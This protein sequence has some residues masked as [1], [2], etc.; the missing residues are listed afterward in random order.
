VALAECWDVGRRSKGQTEGTGVAYAGSGLSK[1][2]LTI[3][4]SAARRRRIAIALA[5][6]M[7]A[8]IA[9]AAQARAATYTVGITSDATGTCSVPSSG[10]CSLRQLIG[11]E[12][13]LSSTP[14]PAD[15][16]VLPAG[17]YDLTNGA[18]VIQQSLTI[19]GAG[20]RTTHIFQETQP[21]AGGA[22]AFR[23]FDILGNPKLNPNPNVTISGVD[24][25][26]GKADSTNAFFGGNVR[27]Q[28]TLTLSEDLIEDGSTTSGSGAGISNDG[29][30]LTVTHSLVWNNTGA[31]DSGGIQNYGDDT[32]GAA[33][34]SI[35]NSTIAD[36]SSSLG[37]GVFSWC[38]GSNG[39]CSPNNTTNNTT[40]ITNSTIAFNNGG[41]RSSTG[42]G[43]FASQGTISVRNSIVASN[44]V[45]NPLSGAQTP[46]NCGGSI[47][48]L[49]DN[50]ETASDC[51]FTAA[52]DLQKTDPGFLTGGIAFNGGNTETFALSGTSPALDAGP[53]SAQGCSGT[54][55]RD[56][57]R[58]QGANCDIGAFEM[59]QPVEGQQFTTIV[60]Q[61]ASTAATINWGDGTSSQG[62]LDSLHQVTGTHTYAEEGVYHAAIN[63]KNSDG[64]SQQTPFDLKVAD[65]P[66]TSSPVS[67]N[68]IVGSQFSGPA[69][70]FTDAN[71]N[72]TVSDYSATITWGDGNRS[73]GT[74]TTNSSGGFMVSGTHTYT[75]AGG[76]KTTITINDVGG[77]STT[78]HGS[79]TV[80]VP[81]PTVTGVSPSAGPTGGGTS[82]TIT[83][84]NL[85]GATGVAFGSTAATSFT[86]NSATQ[87]TATAPAGT[88][89]T[90]D[91]T[92]TTPGGTS[93][94]STADQYTYAAPPTATSVT[95]GAGPTGGGTSVTI[96]GTNLTNA[97]AVQFGGSAAT[98]FTV[99]SA[100]SITATA[101]AESAGTVDVTV[102]TP[103]GTSTTGTP[104]NYTYVAAPSVTSVDPKTGPTAGGTSVTISGKNL[105]GATAVKFGTANATNFTVNSITQITATAPA[106]TARTVD[107]T[108]T[109]AGGTSTT[110]TADQYTYVGAP[111]VTGVSPNA[112]PTAGGTSVTITGTNF[113]NATAV[114]FGGTAATSFTVNNDGQITATAPP[115]TGTVDLTVQTAGGTSATGSADQYAYVPAPTVTGV[116][117]AA[118]PA[119]GGTNVT[120]TGTNFTNA[121]AVS[122]GGTAATSFT[123]DGA[124]QITATAPAGSAGTVDITVTTTGGTSATGTADQYTYAAPPTVSGVSPSAGPL[125]GGTPVTI[126]GTNLTNASAVSFGSTAATSFT[127]NSAT[128]V[129]A[130]A[131]A[132]SAGAVDVTITAPGG[133]TAKSVADQYT[134]TSAPT[135]TGV[136]PASG[137]LA[138]GTTVTISG[139]GLGGATAVSFGSTPAAS[140]T[141]N[142]STQI[143]ATAPAG[144]AGS[145][146]ITVTTPGGTTAKSAADR[147]AYAALPTVTGLSPTAGPAAGGTSVT[148]T[149]TNLTGATAVK[150]GATAATSFTVNNATQIT[151]VAPVEAAGTVDVRV[152]TVGGTSATSAADR[153]TFQAPPSASITA[154]ADNQSFNLNQ[155][156][157]TTFS[158]T[159]GASGS[160]LQSCTDSNG[161]SGGIGVLDT[162]IGGVHAY[163]V[164]A[165]SKDGQTVTATIS[166]TVIGGPTATIGAPKDN[167]IYNLNQAVATTFSCADAASGPGIQTCKD[168]NSGSGG[169]GTLDTS[170]A[171]SHSYTVTALSKDGLTSNKAIHYTVIGPPS[172][173]ITTPTD[174]QTY[175]VNQQVSTA[176]SCTEAASG[177]GVQ[178][179]KDSN[180]GSGGTGALDTSSA[181]AHA[182]T[183]TATSNDGQTGS[184][185]IHYT[186]GTAA[187]PTVSGGAP[188]TT[189]G[190]GAALAGTVNPE[191]SPAQ[192]YFQYGLDLSQ[193]GPGTDSTLYD[194]STTPEPVGSDTSTHTVTASLTGLVPG[195]L[196]HVRLVATNG[197]GT[198]FGPDETFEAAAA[199]A[200]KPPVL[201]ESEDAKP[202]T[203]TVFIKTPSGQFVPLTGATQIRTGAVIDALH[204]S[205]QL[206]AAVGKGKTEHGIFGGAVFKLTQ[207]KAGRLKGLTTLKLLEAA[208]KGAPS[209]A[210]C[211]A[212]AATD[213]T[214]A[215]SKTL[216][217]LKASAHGKFRTTGRYSAATVRGTKWTVAD[218]CDGTFTHVITDSVAVTD[219]VRHKTIILHAGQSYLAKARK[220]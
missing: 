202:V 113:T 218:R 174:N 195:G 116:N 15:T 87:I 80:R 205:L 77:S 127:V 206:L 99:N 200:P 17:S 108:V 197:A 28:A 180:G 121:T 190:T 179:C 165:T 115:G 101:P 150:F 51:G 146:D 46:S 114:K 147:Y 185:T 156:V 81:A 213:A 4:R 75:S 45:I 155:V 217:L 83:G 194:H 18:L 198:T 24:M 12:N 182:Y 210:L 98:S 32:V 133:T 219:F 177:P 124:T 143:T 94:T 42:G 139:G 89:G 131:P 35:D 3:V 172:A 132:G 86:V 103:G 191:G 31:N 102:T 136:S 6:S 152:T 65:A 1:H 93:T 159:E 162:S 181:G 26:F 161:G 130:T 192:A 70:T 138:G 50:I 183:V 104:D 84:T 30:T 123:A 118:G 63:W 220:P 137:P 158:C 54:D 107:I 151:A 211:K 95:P 184:S 111:T 167:Q 215:S 2:A 72:G 201:G 208:F 163:T 29:G 187:P 36:N 189:V 21:Q 20:A 164:T 73:T 149:G 144:S 19:A 153:Y 92:V 117:P 60:G 22:T 199:A 119:A 196:Y 209:Y 48:S 33:T 166:Y 23:V 85:T 128:Q 61:V 125:A 148:I 59:F 173:Q 40:T 38:N 97:S 71:P 5:C 79:A 109:T 62:T 91:V 27:N 112:G 68:A 37:G 43:L 16:I 57:A 207:A 78:A 9:L 47:T 186:V 96:T 203:G 193:R 66:L 56:V 67:I 171:G 14:S 178:T 55:Q 41:T 134:Y 175:G 141:V 11:F 135:V 49:G 154:P 10:K 8:V 13:G 160:G 82:V 126:T 157:P 34:L 122:F 168:S 25:A 105:T 88:A 69:A 145:V 76:F 216:Q 204:G 188:T 106:G 212:H 58:P 44:T 169:T 100:T 7:L 90:V 176:F 142:N 129:T 53:S 120:I 74:I 52:G 64:V 110:G 214:I 39:E 170:T 140:F